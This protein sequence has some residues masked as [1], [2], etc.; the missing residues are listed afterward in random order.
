MGAGAAGIEWHR[1]GLTV[2]VAKPGQSSPSRLIPLPHRF[3]SSFVNFSKYVLNAWVPG[4]RAKQGKYSWFIHLT[5]I[6]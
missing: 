3:I 4:T 2:R 1:R 6:C 5:N